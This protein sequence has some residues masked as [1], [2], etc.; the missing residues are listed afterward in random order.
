M[1]MET[2]LSNSPFVTYVIVISKI[3]HFMKF[4]LKATSATKLLIP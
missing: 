2:V 1:I 4:L 3:T